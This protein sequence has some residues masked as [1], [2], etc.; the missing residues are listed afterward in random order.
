M[1]YLIGF[2]G[3]PKVGENDKPRCSLGMQQRPNSASCIAL[4]HQLHL[5]CCHTANRNQV[6]FHL[7]L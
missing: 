5:V 1:P 3:G 7:V 2:P 4:S 6:M